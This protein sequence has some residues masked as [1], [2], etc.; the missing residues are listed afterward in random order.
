MSKYHELLKY[1][2]VLINIFKKYVDYI[3]SPALKDIHRYF[4]R[5]DTL[6]G[7]KLSLN[8]AVDA[9]AQSDIWEQKNIAKEILSVT[10]Y[11]FKGE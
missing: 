8:M 9:F 1:R 2:V 11:F 6:N 5:I 7:L 4:S 3:K 10:T